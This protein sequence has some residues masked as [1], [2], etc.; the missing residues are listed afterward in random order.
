MEVIT[1]SNHLKTYPQELARTKNL[2]L[3][4]TGKVLSEAKSL[5]SRCEH[6]KANTFTGSFFIFAGSAWH[7]TINAG[8]NCRTSMIFQYSPPSEDVR[9]PLSFEKPGV[10]AEKKP[11]CI[12][13]SGQ[14]RFKVTDTVPYPKRAATSEMRSHIRDKILCRDKLQ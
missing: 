5:D 4:D 11:P 3:T 2:D 13:V 6:I 9:I 8:K 12:L 10:W 14:D 1:Y 7:Y